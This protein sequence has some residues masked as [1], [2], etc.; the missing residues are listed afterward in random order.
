MIAQIRNRA[1]IKEDMLAGIVEWQARNSD[2][3]GWLYVPETTLDCPVFQSDDNLFYLQH[4]DDKEADKNG[5][6]M[7][8]Y[9]DVFGGRENQ[10]KN[11]ILYGH[12]KDEDPDGG[13]EASRL[14]EHFTELK[15][16]QDIDF[17]KRNPYVMFAAGDDAMVW[18]IF[19]VF[20]T[21]TEFNY[22]RTKPSTDQLEEILTE[23]RQKSL[24]N[25][26]V[27]LGQSERYLTLST[28]C[29]RIVP[30]YPNGYRFVIMARLVEK[31]KPLTYDTAITP[32]PTALTPDNIYE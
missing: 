19:A 7:A 2:T 22:I 9:R 11:L 3:A 20:H 5:A 14:Y 10:S 6:I 24:F 17:C 4:N 8:D 31:G 32:N 30:T 27:E 25:F 12:S 16:Y 18:E 26:D 28:C 21:K 13:V 29:R 1:E 15:R 23:A